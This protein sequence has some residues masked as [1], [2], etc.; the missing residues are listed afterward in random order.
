MEFWGTQDLGRILE[1]EIGPS[2]EFGGGF[3]VIIDVIWD[4]YGFSFVC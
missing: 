4:G 3:L 1:V 2:W